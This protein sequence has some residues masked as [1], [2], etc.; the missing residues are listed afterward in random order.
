MLIKRF[1]QIFRRIN[2]VLEYLIVEE[3]SLSR[4]QR[5]KFKLRRRLPKFL[6]LR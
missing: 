5:L 4:F 3:L 1:S 2:G 6:D